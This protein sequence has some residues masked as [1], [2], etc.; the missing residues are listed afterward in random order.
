MPLTGTGTIIGAAIA[1]ALVTPAAA[2]GWGAILEVLNTWLPQNTLVM[3]GTMAAAGTAVTGAGELSIEGEA[4]DLGPQLAAAAGSPPTD[5]ASIAK[6]TQIAQALI[7]HLQDSCQVNPSGFTSPG[8]PV[9]PNPIGGT[10]TLT[11]PSPT[12]GSEIASA[13]NCTDAPGIA[14]WVLVGTN[15][16]LH[17][18]TNTT[19]NPTPIG[20]VAPAGGGPLTGTGT[21]I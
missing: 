19:V 13:I 5:T 14:G 18:S 21:I 7:D 15:I 3:P 9:N 4:S 16:Q 6:W 17:L 20:L 10:G 2:A 8:S 1:T 11:F 12:L